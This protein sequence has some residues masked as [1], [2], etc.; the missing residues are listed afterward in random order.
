[1]ADRLVARGTLEN[2]SIA[3][4]FAHHDDDLTMPFTCPEC[5]DTG[6]RQRF[7]SFHFSCPGCNLSVA[8]VDLA[9]TGIVREVFGW[10]L[11][12]GT[13]LADRYRV[14]SL[15]G[16]GGFA[17]TYGVADT[18]LANRRCALKEVPRVLFD[19]GEMEIL[20]RL[21]HPGIPN[22][23]DKFEL[24]S[25]VYLVLEF[26]GSRS[27]ATERIQR[28]GTIPA[29]T[30]LPWISQLCGVLEYLH[31][32]DPPIVHRDLKPGNVLLTEGGR[33]NL[34]D[35]GIAKETL[36]GTQTRTIAR[37]ATHG[38]SPP[39]QVLGTG[40]DE[41]SDVYSLGA[42]LFQLLTGH[43][44]PPA[45]ERVAG[46]EL[47]RPGSLVE[48]V[49][50]TLDELILRAMELNIHKRIQSIRDFAARLDAISA[51]EPIPLM[52]TDSQRPL[53]DDAP[54]LG[55]DRRLPA[56]LSDAETLYL[57]SDPPAFQT[58]SRSGE[59]RRFSAALVAWLVFGLAGVGGA[60]WWLQ[61]E[62]AA[63]SERP[64]QVAAV[65][66]PQPPA[67]GSQTDVASPTAPPIA[68]APEAN[69]PATPD[70]VRESAGVQL[71]PDS[72]P[73]ST[74][75]LARIQ[76]ERQSIPVPIP[77]QSRI[78]PGPSVDPVAPARLVPPPSRP[79]VSTLASDGVEPVPSGTSEQ[80][81]PRSPDPAKP[82]WGA[83]F[84]K[85]SVRRID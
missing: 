71:E 64:A 24:G 16:R 70:S 74:P 55:S 84:K 81:E 78:E 20:S 34:I 33:I 63:R 45:H 72:E 52:S 8:H 7:A 56:N 69:A 30:L 80:V 40:T 21:D 82:N 59:T 31:A 41:R 19:S 57:G 62:P 66:E 32:Q 25:M 67:L 14:N 23:R 47:A 4:S 53:A 65:P 18:R 85:G 35:F 9:P 10:L 39:E 76:P 27:L 22:I 28:G 1:M 61:R 6:A 75:D 2:G 46:A 17:A 83:G 11:P 12:P 5:G 26:G 3:M 38:F 60:M 50:P 79:V 15:L 49:S 68:I 37:S 77:V 58:S 44:P 48:G 43:K 13:L 73:Q 42:T 54:T 36:T 51:G 29:A